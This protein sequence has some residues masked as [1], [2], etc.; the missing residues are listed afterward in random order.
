MQ[1]PSWGKPEEFPF[2]PRAGGFPLISVSRPVAGFLTCVWSHPEMRRKSTTAVRS[3][4]VKI[5]WEPEGWL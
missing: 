1:A 5:G 4:A 2:I 3:S